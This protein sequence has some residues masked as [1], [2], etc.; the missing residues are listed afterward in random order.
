[1]NFKRFEFFVV[2][3]FDVSFYNLFFNIIYLLKNFEFRN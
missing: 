1:M 2:A 3:E